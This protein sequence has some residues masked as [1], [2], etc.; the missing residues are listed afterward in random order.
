VQ[1]SGF[2]KGIARN[3]NKT[4]KNKT[5]EQFEVPDDRK[6]SR[7]VGFYGW[8]DWERGGKSCWEL[9][10]LAALGCVLR[11][12]RRAMAEVSSQEL[13]TLLAT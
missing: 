10:T 11:C 9:A 7:D 3:N 6:P 8:R 13:A 1:I 4:E 5:I 2:S 12:S